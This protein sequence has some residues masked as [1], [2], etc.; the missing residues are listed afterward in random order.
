MARTYRTVKSNSKYRSIDGSIRSTRQV[1]ILNDGR[2]VYKKE[3]FLRN[4]SNVLTKIRIVTKDK[5]KTVLTTT[6]EY[7]WEKRNR[8][9]IPKRPRT[10]SQFKTLMER[11]DY[12]EVFNNI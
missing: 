12:E 2:I 5:G 8:I 9:W 11:N 7:I 6:Y 10:R 3:Y 1:H 4:I